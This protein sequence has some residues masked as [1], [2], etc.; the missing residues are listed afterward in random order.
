MQFWK[1]YK[2]TAIGFSL[3]V[4]LAVQPVISTGEID[5]KQFIVAIMVGALGFLAK[6]F[7]TR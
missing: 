7:D 2:T 3:A 6:D 5:W 1:N 4:L